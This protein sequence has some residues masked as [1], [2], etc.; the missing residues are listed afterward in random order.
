MSGATAHHQ[1]AQSCRVADREQRANQR[2]E[3]SADHVHRVGDAQRLQQL[4][5][6]VGDAGKLKGADRFLRPAGTPEISGNHPAVG[7]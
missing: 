2:A 4:R 3:C 5:D 6:V 1:P 7:R